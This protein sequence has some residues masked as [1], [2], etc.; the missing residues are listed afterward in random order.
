M[1]FKNG[2]FLFYNV[3]FNFGKLLD[4]KFFKVFFYKK[5]VM[6]FG[7]SFDVNILDNVMF[8]DYEFFC[9]FYCGVGMVGYM[10]V[11]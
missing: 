8:G 5:L 9:F 2:M 3:M 11:E 10:I 6:K 1:I 7:E 4:V